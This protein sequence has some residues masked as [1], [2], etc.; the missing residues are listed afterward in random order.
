MNE[1]TDASAPII[2][3]GLA[4][5]RELLGRRKGLPEQTFRREH[6]NIL[7][8]ASLGL[9]AAA[10]RPAA[11]E[12][13]LRAFPL[14]ENGGQWG[15]W[16]PLFQAMGEM[17]ENGRSSPTDQ[18]TEAHCLLR[19]GQLQRL[20]HQYDTAIATHQAAAALVAHLPAANPLA[21][22]I[23]YQLGEDY[24]LRGDL[25]AARPY[26]RTAWRLA[27]TLPS[28]HHQQGAA[29]NSLGLIAWASGELEEAAAWFTIAIP[30]WRELESWV[31]LG[32]TLSNLGNVRQNQ[33]ALE[34]ALI[35]YGQALAELGKTAAWVEVLKVEYN[36]SVLHFVREEYAAAEQSLRAAY[37][38]LSGQPPGSGVMLRAYVCH[39]LGS[40]ILKQGRP[41]EAEPFLRQSLAAWATIGDELNRANSLG[42][43]GEALAGQGQR[44]AACASYGEAVDLLATRRE[45]P[46]GEKL[47]QEFRA[48]GAALGCGGEP[49]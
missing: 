21:S 3:A 19:L 34:E 4:Y 26:A 43:L 5:W 42:A 13:A 41:A 29:A 31:E 16:L 46:R 25:A 35:A 11:I 6:D 36:I 39:S 32:R 30:L 7:R 44:V 37:R 27:K 10:T 22:G 40:A 33:G 45:T 1:T 14:A 18:E 2:L 48:V 15:E 28:P 47:Y 9:G 49:E 20:S 23:Q 38:S 12:L 8:A 17:L 24:R